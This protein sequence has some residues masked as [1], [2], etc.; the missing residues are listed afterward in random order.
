MGSAK[1]NI[2]RGMPNSDEEFIEIMEKSILNSA[3]ALELQEFDNELEEKI[4][5]HI[6]LLEGGDILKNQIPMEL[7]GGGKIEQLD[8]DC[9]CGNKVTE[10]TT[11]GH[12]RKVFNSAHILAMSHCPQCHNWRMVDLRIRKYEGEYVI[13]YVN[14]DGVWVRSQSK[15]K[16]QNNFIENVK[17]IFKIS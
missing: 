14:K 4:M 3:I 9:S 17:N 13:E 11:F 2:L 6:V 12:I 8:I 16:K 5:K 1:Q 7:E 10:E 15:V